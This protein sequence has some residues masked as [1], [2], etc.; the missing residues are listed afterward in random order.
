MLRIEADI[1]KE[2]EEEQ[3]LAA[4]ELEEDSEEYLQDPDEDLEEAEEQEVS[5]EDLANQAILLDYGD[6]DFLDEDDFAEIFQRSPD[7]E[8][9]LDYL[10]SVL[11]PQSST[12]AQAKLAYKRLARK[13]EAKADKPKPKEPNPAPA[14][15][16]IEK[17][18]SSPPPQ[19]G[20]KQASVA[21]EESNQDQAKAILI[22]Y[23]S[24]PISAREVMRPY[25]IR[26]LR[27]FIGIESPDFFLDYETQAE[28]VDALY[29]YMD[30]VRIPT[31]AYTTG[32]EMVIAALLRHGEK[33]LVDAISK[34]KPIVRPTKKEP[35]K[36]A[37]KPAP[38]SA[39]ASADSG[40]ETKLHKVARFMNSPKTQEEIAAK[41]DV[42]TTA[43]GAYIRAHIPQKLGL[44][45]FAELENGK[46]A[47]WFP[48]DKRPSGAKRA[49]DGR[50]WIKEEV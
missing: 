46:F 22:G 21:S 47:P 16:P 26:G 7:A 18:A 5:E 49:R 31:E 34:I 42:D 10:I 2:W 1:D 50:Y 23:Y 3:T 40:K 15:A 14:P 33:D 13:A 9:M 43:V 24:S 11:R 19:A 8:S 6:P 4:Q 17:P 44:T 25:M 29:E 36:P 27:D 41:F 28:A 20:K 35:P 45:I 48:T 12:L 30:P 39:Q 32:F 37:P 38:R